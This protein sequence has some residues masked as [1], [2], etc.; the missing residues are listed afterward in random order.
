MSRLWSIG[1]LLGCSV[2]VVL[3]AIENRQLTR[4]NEVL[5]RRTTGPYPGMIVP[6]VRSATLAGDTVVLGDATETG[7]RQLLLIFNTR[8]EFCRASLPAWERLAATVREPGVTPTE[9]VGVSLDSVGPTR[10]YAAEHRLGYPV[11]FLSA[12]D[13]V[14]YRAQMVPTLLLLDRYG[15]TIYAR[16]GLLDAP[17]AIDSVIAILRRPP[18]KPAADSTARGAPPLRRSS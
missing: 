13:P 10:Q 7:A 11:A 3:L 9:V 17:A 8:C 15:R 18:A 16:R 6:T 1:G 2:L 5:L 12:K 4:R 14:L